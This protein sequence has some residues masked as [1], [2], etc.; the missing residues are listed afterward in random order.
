MKAPPAGLVTLMESTNWDG[1]FFNWNDDFSQ[2]GRDGTG[3]YLWAWRTHLIKWISQTNR[4]GS[5]YLPTLELLEE[6]ARECQRTG[7]AAAGEIQG[8]QAR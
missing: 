7:D 3:A 5:C 6:A 8:C 2:S 1:S 4:D